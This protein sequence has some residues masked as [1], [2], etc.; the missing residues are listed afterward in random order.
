MQVWISHGFDR[1]P[2]EGKQHW[3]FFSMV[4][5]LLPN[6]FTGQGWTTAFT[7]VVYSE[8]ETD[9][10][11]IKASFSLLF[12]HTVSIFLASTN[13]VTVNTT[14]GSHFDLIHLHYQRKKRSPL[15]III[16]NTAS[17]RKGSIILG[18]RLQS[19]LVSTY[20]K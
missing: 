15:L 5:Y 11:P 3:K 19:N 12:F 2:R 16:C 1:F 13:W 10:V 20:N 4:Y 8:V 14:S 9:S 18:R 7:A 17:L 6:N